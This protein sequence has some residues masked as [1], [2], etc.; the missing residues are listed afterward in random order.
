MRKLGPP[1]EIFRLAAPLSRILDEAWQR[2]HWWVGGMAALYLL[3][4]IT[5]VKPDEVAVILRWGRLVGATP[6]LQEH[7]PGILF[8][9]PKPI[10]QVERVPVKRVEALQIQALDFGVMQPNFP[11]ASDELRELMGSSLD[12]VKQGYAITGDQNVVHVSIVAR[13]RIRDAAEWIYYAPMNDDVLATEVSAAMTRSLGEMGVD[14]VLSDGRKDLVA[15]VTRR[16]QEGLDAVHSGLE[17][18]SLELKRLAPPIALARDFDAVQSAYINAQTKQNE[19]EAFKQKAL[20][21][22][23]AAADAEVQSAQGDSE[24]ALARARGESQAFLT[25]QHEYKSNPA[26]VRER[27]YRDA[28]DRAISRSG[29]VQWVP[30]PS[31]G[32]YRGFRVSLSF[33]DPSVPPRVDNPDTSAPASPLRTDSISPTSQYRLEE[34]D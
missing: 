13:Y 27:L 21:A 9:F 1:S 7:G 10:D 20:P 5:V 8:A 19:A 33:A 15:L 3:S 31:G 18:V 12:P 22:A 11:G 17:L 34:N 16:T 25:L 23:R 2:M 32:S 29:G 24:S 14:R 4:G 28:I 26:V 30:P 6:A